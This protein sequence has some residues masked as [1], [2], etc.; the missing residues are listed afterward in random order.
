M[1]DYCRRNSYG[2]LEKAMSSRHAIESARSIN[3]KEFLERKK[4]TLLS[5]FFNPL[6]SELIESLG[7]LLLEQEITQNNNHRNIIE[8]IV[9][10]FDED[11]IQIA[12]CYDENVNLE[13]SEEV[14]IL[15]ETNE[16]KEIGLFSVKQMQQV[17]KIA[18]NKVESLNVEE[19]NSLTS[20]NF[21]LDFITRFRKQCKNTKLRSIFYPL[22]N[23]DFF[24]AVKMH[25]YKMT[26]TPNCARCG[27]IESNKHLLF[28]CKSSSEM[29]ESYNKVMNNTSDDFKQIKSFDDIFDFG[30]NAL[31][32]IVK[33]KLIQETIQITRPTY[34]CQG[35]VEN[36][37][38]EQRELNHLNN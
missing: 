20:S 23:K 13:N 1:T 18:L 8:R 14:F 22:L 38:K 30:G 31:V 24:Y 6:R 3:V 28:E 15:D 17:L 4:H 2:G 11:T 27:Q 21:R 7:D 26:E 36:I 32:N 12:S 34:W 16:L 5:C 37:T 25:K 19:K 10:V 29:W 35:R 33:I 9:K